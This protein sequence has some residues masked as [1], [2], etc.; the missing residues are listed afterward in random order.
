MQIENGLVTSIDGIKIIQDLIPVIN[1]NA[2]PGIKMTSEYITIH[3]TGNS[4]A[5][6]AAN[7]NYVDN[8]NEYV[9]W[10]FTVGPNEVYQEMPITEH[11]WHAGDGSTGDGNMKSIGVEIAEVDGA[12]ETA[13]NFIAQLLIALN[14]NID[15]V[16]P[17]QHWSGKY[18]PRLILPHWD[19]FI[20][21]VENEMEL[22]A[23]AEVKR[24]KNISE[25]PEW[26]QLYVKKW[27]NEGYIKG[28]TT[29]EL[30][31]SEDMV[32]VLIVAERMIGQA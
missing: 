26:M 2:R 9:S 12:E 11:A 18:C 7:S 23:V 30:D 25:M 31:F 5:S 8:Q 15:K 1:T 17:H 14:M 3:N 24:Y 27:V 22:I 29:G 4:G 28:N 21:N 16:V 19:T 10:H 13:M 6:A 20:K 32:R